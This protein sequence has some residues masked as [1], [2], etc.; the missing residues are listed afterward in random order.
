MDPIPITRIGSNGTI[1]LDISANYVLTINLGPEF[2]GFVGGDS[3]TT[4]YCQG[5][6]ITAGAT[7]VGADSPIVLKNIVLINLVT[8]EQWGSATTDTTCQS[9]DLSGTPIPVVIAFED[10]DYTLTCGNIYSLSNGSSIND[11]FIFNISGS[12]NVLV[13]GNGTTITT[14]LSGLFQSNAANQSI[15]IQDLNVTYSGAVLEANNGCIFSQGFANMIAKSVAISFA[16]CNWNVGGIFPGNNVGFVVAE[17]CRS[18]VNGYIKTGEMTG[19]GGGICGGHNSGIVN[20]ANCSANVTQYINNHGQGGGGGILGGHNGGIVNI[21]NCSANVAQ[22]IDNHGQGGGGGMCGGMN[23]GT[24]ILNSCNTNVSGNLDN[25]YAYG[26]G[27]GI[28]GGFQQS[29][30]FL[31]I[32]NCSAKIAGSVDIHSMSGG[33]G[34]ICGG[35]NRGTTI[36]LTNCITTILGNIDNTDGN[37]GGGGICGGFNEGN[38]GGLM[39]TISNCS[40]TSA[41]IFNHNVGGGGGICGGYNLATIA[42]RSCSV[43]VTGNIENDGANG[44]GGGI[45][46]GYNRDATIYIESCCTKVV[47]D[48]TNSVSRVGG[49]GGMCGGCNTGA[50]SILSCLTDISGVANS[51][52]DGNGAGGGGGLCGGGNN[53]VTFTIEFCGVSVHSI[54]SINLD[55]GPGGLCGGNNVGTGGIITNCSVY[56]NIYDPQALFCPTY[57]LLGNNTY[58]GT[59]P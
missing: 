47:G 33:G 11:T 42:I 1:V 52:T 53:E 7:Y 15:M 13:L 51:A 25:S 18:I 40:V 46:G 4:V 21:S 55:D 5:H 56:T 16:G 24:I 50:I 8:F 17:N 45:C 14:S 57:Y 48:I 49:G 59:N 34:G 23:Y 30:C 28:C 31:Q 6:T 2:V 27:G 38:Y 29:P 39:L 32:T 41:N 26:G 9:F 43:S 3:S 37:G 58:D 10:T 20:I 44:G 19:G 36:I 22:Y 12:G 54:G 35:D